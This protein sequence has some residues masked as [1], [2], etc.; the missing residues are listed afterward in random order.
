MVFMKARIISNTEIADHIYKLELQG[1]FAE[2]VFLPG[3]FLHIKTGT[4]AFLRR[5]MSI[6]DVGIGSMTVLYRASGLGTRELAGQTEGVELDILA[7]LGRGFPLDTLATKILL[8]GGGI[9]VPPLYYLGRKLKE[10]GKEIISLLGFNSKKDIFFEEEFSQLGQVHISTIDS[11]YGHGGYV[12]DLIPETYD[13]MY[14]CGP[15]PMLKALQNIIPSN[16]EAY[17]SLEERMGCGIGACLAC[18][19]K[20]ADDETKYF[21]VCKEGPVFKINEVALR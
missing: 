9:G 18:V 3:Q 5:P 14:S 12:T 15:S 21:R 11:S 20:N 19:C 10:Q 16:K 1:D 6:C 17:I 2:D 8:I 13:A 7:P 4:Q